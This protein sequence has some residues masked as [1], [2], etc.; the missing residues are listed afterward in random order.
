MRNV[1]VLVTAS[2][3]LLAGCIE[4]GD[5]DTETPELGSL[6]ARAEPLWH[7]PQDFPHPAFGW[8]TL[9]NPPT[10]D[11]VPDWWN[12]IPEAPL[13]ETISA[14]KHVAGAPEEIRHGGGFAAFGSLLSFPTFWGNTFILDISEPT[15]PKV[16][17]EIERSTRGAVMIPYP[18]GTLITVYSTNSQLL[19]FDITDPT[20][21]VDLGA[22]D[23]VQGSHKV[24]VVP[25]TPI[26]Y[27][28]A[29]YGGGNAAESIAPGMAHGVTE[30]YDL[31]DPQ[32]PVHVMDF[33]NGYSCHH[34]YFHI[35]P[36][37]G[38]FYAIC[39]GKAMTQ[40]W[41]ISDPLDPIIVSEVP[42]PLGHPFPS[43]GG[44][45]ATFSHFS[46]LNND[47]TVLI[48]GDEPGGG[49]YPM[50]DVHLD[51]AGQS[52]SGP[53]GNL[54]FYDITNMEEPTLV[55]WY[56]PTNHMPFNPPH[57]EQG[58]PQGFAGCTA[59]HGRLIPDPQGRDLI[60]MPFYGAGP[61]LLDFSD[62][63]NPIPLHQ[64]MDNTNT[65]EVWYYNGYIFTGDLSRG[66]DV[67]TLS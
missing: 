17:S 57:D 37:A 25:G 15:E 36:A 22:L 20:D 40:I 62:P 18:D 66:M 14:L 61:V 65:W 19:I 10:G 28:A 64:W 48:V 58:G 2:A 24:G 12:P 44:T 8:P 52:I 30:I 32:N 43:L 33:E 9:T 55:G 51:V 7:A 67:F 16:L 49:S 34:V 1:V 63:S 13:P 60:A 35:D 27:N 47:A 39:A 46:I 26:V 5:L 29:S 54:W 50:C 42:M 56:S 59:H 41:D 53:L 4:P 31:S 21:P 11:H 45:T 38:N 6:L 23:P 3:L